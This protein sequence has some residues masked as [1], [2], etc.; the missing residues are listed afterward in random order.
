MPHPFVRNRAT[1]LAYIALA[2]YG[3][4]LNIFGPITP[5]LKNE[6]ELSYTVSS[7]HFSAFALGII[8]AGLIGN[9]VIQ[10]VGRWNALWI[11][12]FGMSA[13]ALLLIAGRDAS[14]TIGAS[15]LMGLV[16]S[17]ILA[18]VPSALSDQHGDMRAVAL[19]EANVFSSLFSASAPVLVGW[20][21]L[22]AL[23]WR[24]A[25]VVAVL[26]VVVIRVG[27]N[28]VSLPPMAAPKTADQHEPPLSILYWLYWTALVAAV[29]VE[30]CLIFWSA[31]Y[32]ETSLGMPTAEAAQAVSVFLGSMIVG[33]LAG[34]RLVRHISAHRVITASLII[35]TVGFLL[36][37]TAS[38][39]LVGM[40]GLG[41]AGLGT[42]SLYPLILA[43]SIET[44]RGST[45][46]ASALASLA[47]GTAILALPLILGRLA[48]AVGIRPAYAVVIVLLVAAFA[49]T[50]GAARLA[51][52]STIVGEIK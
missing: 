41:I 21:A 40:I 1:W 27:F 30:F 49:I 4:F 22:S 37:W 38:T 28:R 6:L 18:V 25:L 35:D 19:S 51:R 7:L 8:G 11:S 31:D 29:S 47:S 43:F 14:L 2:L 44:S 9:R 23:G 16:G 48:D 20:F 26:A 32:L 50:Q 45:V 10:R 12:A 13:C 24:M 46:R 17:L 52:R 36:Y 3:Y 33:R 34:S 15:F 5:F 39:P 42:A